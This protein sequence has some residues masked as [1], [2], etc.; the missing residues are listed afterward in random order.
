M[1]LTLEYIY[2]NATDLLRRFDLK[3]TFDASWSKVT[4][5]IFEMQAEFFELYDLPNNIPAKED[6]AKELSD[7]LITLFNML[8]TLDINPFESNLLE[9]IE[10]RW[11]M[12]TLEDTSPRQV[13]IL[14][15]SS[16]YDLHRV[17]FHRKHNPH[18]V[19]AGC[20]IALDRTLAF[21]LG[22][23]KKSG[24]TL[25]QLEDAMIVTVE[26]NA[27]KTHDTHEIRNGQICKRIPM[28]A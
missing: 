12:L 22:M 18:Y 24:I 3:P 15:A 16:T 25:K 6:A 28:E 7:V 17:L 21:L 10:S 8:Y 13:A 26:K 27:K 14:F 19:E 1:T 11:G 4:E 23:A 9:P 5:E 2:D 20:L